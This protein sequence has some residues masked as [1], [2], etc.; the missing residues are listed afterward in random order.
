[1]SETPA[2]GRTGPGYIKVWD[3]AVRVF[4]WA[5]V[6]AFA[7]AWLS[8]ESE[9]WQLIHSGFGYAVLALVAFRLVWGFVGGRYARFAS[10]AFGWPAVRDYLRSLL[11]P[12]PEHY[13]GHN[14]AGSWAI[15]LLLALAIVTGLSGYATLN[16][17]GGDLLEELHEGAANLMILVVVVHVAGVLVSSWLHGENLVRAMIDGRKRAR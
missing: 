10:F 17:I 16:E 15:Y 3:P 12:R 8:G 13:L 6:T 4:H 14:P 5:L 7:G 11:G 2:N 1:M 9:R